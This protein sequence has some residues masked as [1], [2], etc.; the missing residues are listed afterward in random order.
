MTSIMIPRRGK[1]ALRTR[2]LGIVMKLT[3]NFISVSTHCGLLLHYF[4]LNIFF[5][6]KKSMRVDLFII[7]LLMAEASS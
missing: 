6:L 2:G 7:Y 5:K 4:I 1:A 3:S